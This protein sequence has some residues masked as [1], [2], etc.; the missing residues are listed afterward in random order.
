MRA[1]WFTL[2]WMNVGLGLIGAVLPLMPTTIFLIVAAGC[3]A[4]SSPE[5]ERW[6][7]EH[8]RF[9]PP[10]RDWRAHGAIRPAAKRAAV[11]AMALS[12]AP[13]VILGAPV[14]VMATQAVAL[15]AV[16]AFLIT[17]PA[18]PLDAIRPTRPDDERQT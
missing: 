12:M 6:L 2:G 13:T 17:R 16:A 3:F 14:W 11:L 10:L 9:G 15:T 1:V 8:P 7:V 5:L 18:P 4:R